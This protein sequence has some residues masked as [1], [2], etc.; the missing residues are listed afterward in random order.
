MRIVLTL[1]NYDPLIVIR[2]PMHWH[3]LFSIEYHIVTCKS[4]F[5]H[6]LPGYLE[7]PSTCLPCHIQVNTW[8]T[9]TIINISSLLLKKIT[10][11]RPLMGQLPLW[12]CPSWN[13]CLK[14]GLNLALLLLLLFLLLLHRRES[15]SCT[16]RF[17]P[18]LLRTS[19]IR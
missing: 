17:L 6:H 13:N 8:S 7:V 16:C 1:F 4:T 11:N 10:K 9:S 12:N 15:S 19:S 18:D 2:Y 3:S 14:P 5:C